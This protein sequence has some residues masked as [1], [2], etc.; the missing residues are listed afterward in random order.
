MGS[1][2]DTAPSGNNP[3][4]PV[5]GPTWTTV[6]ISAPPWFPPQAAVRSM[7]RY[8]CYFGKSEYLFPIES[9]EFGTT[10]ILI[11]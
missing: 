4:A 7:T 6:W 10:K 9:I 11:E 3:P 8:C 2:W 1:P 5:W